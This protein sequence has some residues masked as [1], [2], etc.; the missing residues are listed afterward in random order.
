MLL[1]VGPALAGMV[2]IAPGG[3]WCGAINAAAPGDEVVLQAGEHAG[4]C[5]L[6]ASGSEG[7]PVTLRG[8]DPA[9][10]PAI[11][12]EGA[13]SNVI[14]VLA[15]H[16]VIRGLA[17]GPTQADIDGVKIKSGSHVTVE[18]CAFTAMGGVS[19][20]A[21]SA[22]SEGVAVLG[23]TFRDLR[24]TAIYLGCHDGSG[25]C[26]AADVRV[27]GNLVDGVSSSGV[28][29]GVEVK[30][31]SWGSVR[32]NVIHDTQGPGIEMFGSEDPARASVVAGNLVVRSRNNASLEVGGSHVTVTDN[33]VI[34]G[35]DGGV[36]V[37]PYWDA[38][39]DVVVAG[40]T[41]VGEGAAAVRVD[42]A[43]S[44]S[45][46][47]DNA[48]HQAGGG[49]PLPGALSGLDARGNVVC[50]DASACWTDAAAW[51]F[52]PV[53]GSPL[54]AGEAEPTLVTDFCG[55]PRGAVP[56]VGALE[57]TGAA[58][59]GPLAVALKATFACP[60]GGDTGSTDTGST[61][62]GSTDTDPP[63]DS[64]GDDDGG[65]DPAASGCGCATSP[66][67]G[68][69]LGLLAA[70]AARRRR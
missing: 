51:D 44:A 13:S 49:D 41:V 17:F 5:T 36:Y 22:D 31:D 11:V 30:R 35:G 33:V 19:V 61:D 25:S 65:K 3:D 62:S 9:D 42:P 23:S 43:V 63:A 20:A 2:V 16:V 28:G 68:A 37:Y 14:D 32:D 29:Y 10:P 56:Q 46:L 54:A 27:E 38:V 60:E 48:V 40:N 57:R 59:P 24:A 50:E 26:T 7:L 52:W 53:A 70:L 64:G 6:R 8:E 66:G 58:G 12:Y 21:N 47:V 55:Q 15:S 45:R 67:G 1:L 34:G 39:H 4:P 18:G 69:L